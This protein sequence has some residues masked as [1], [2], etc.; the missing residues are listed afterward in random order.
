MLATCRFD[1]VIPSSNAQQLWEAL[2]R[3]TWFK[4]PCGHYT[5]FPYFWWTMSRG[6]DHLDQLLAPNAQQVGAGL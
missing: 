3:P 5:L 6:A 2:D 1:T 4:L